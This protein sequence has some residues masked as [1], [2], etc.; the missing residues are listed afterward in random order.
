MLGSPLKL[1]GTP[2]N[3]DRAPPLLG[4]HT[5]EVL[6]QALNYSDKHIAQ[7]RSEGVI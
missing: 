5:S 6:V 3:C 4:E 7:L 1:T 2:P